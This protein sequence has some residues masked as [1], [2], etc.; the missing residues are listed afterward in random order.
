[1]VDLSL[2]VG[3]KCI[4][5]GGNIASID[6]NH[7][8]H[9]GSYP[10]KLVLHN[11]SHWTVTKDG[12]VWGSKSQ[13]VYNVKTILNEMSQP[14]T[15]IKPIPKAPSRPRPAPREKFFAYYNHDMEEL[16]RTKELP[17]GTLITIISIDCSEKEFERYNMVSDAL[18][19]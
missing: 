17:T 13:H 19:K 8:N 9:D 1:M 11:G 5:E 18:S 3:H 7:D 16:Q 14:S 2:Y 12:Y 10:F 15:E 4:T 6:I